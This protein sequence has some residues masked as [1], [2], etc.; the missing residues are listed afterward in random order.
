MYW[1]L[2]VNDIQQVRYI[3]ITLNR[4][5]NRISEV[6]EFCNYFL[7]PFNIILGENVCFTIY[8]F[9]YKVGCSLWHHIY[10]NTYDTKITYN[11]YIFTKHQE[12]HMNSW[13]QFTQRHHLHFPS[14]IYLFIWRRLQTSNFLRSY[15]THTLTHH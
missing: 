10:N 11:I 14:F 2:V 3:D 8:F 4:W 15:K 7:F 13:K 9:E 6:I 12:K 1:N 5:K